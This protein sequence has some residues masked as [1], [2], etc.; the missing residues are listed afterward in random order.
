M[1]QCQMNAGVVN[2][3]KFFP[4]VHNFWRCSDDEN[5]PLRKN[6]NKN[7]RRVKTSTKVTL[8]ILNG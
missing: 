2:H 6:W 5:W 7:S 8:N 3:P 1:T 4:T